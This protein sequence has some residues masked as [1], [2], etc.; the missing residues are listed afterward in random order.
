MNAD[1]VVILLFDHA[2]VPAPLLPCRRGSDGLPIGRP[3]VE[4]R[5][6]D[7]RVLAAAIEA[8]TSE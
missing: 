3:P 1:C 5:E 6:R 4:P 7:R 2:L 8:P